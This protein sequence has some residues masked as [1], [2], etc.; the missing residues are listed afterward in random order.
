MG[1]MDNLF[2]RP[3]TDDLCNVIEWGKVKPEVNSISR[4]LMVD[5]QLVKLKPNDD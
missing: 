4:F 5:E 3:C 1:T 2:L